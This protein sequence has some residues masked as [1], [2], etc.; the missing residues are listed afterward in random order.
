[1]QRFPVDESLA[2]F[3]NVI[4][5]EFAADLVEKLHAVDE[6][7][8]SLRQLARKAIGLEDIPS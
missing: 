5:G 3:Q 1:L 7:T 6:R 2:R 4:A 8:C